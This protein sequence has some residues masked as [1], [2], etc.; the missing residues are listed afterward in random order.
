MSKELE[1]LKEIKSCL[2]EYFIKNLGYLFDRIETELKRLEILEK[3]YE[4]QVEQTSY[5]NN[6]GLKYKIKSE[7]QDEILRI[8]KEKHVNIDWLLD[9]ES[10]EEYNESLYLD[11]A[12]EEY[13]L[14]K[15][16]LE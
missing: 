13:D 6:L 12:Q 5:Y 4:N 1:A 11:L 9:C 3:N 14:L 10:V 7:K 15:E 16:V 2:T 8:I